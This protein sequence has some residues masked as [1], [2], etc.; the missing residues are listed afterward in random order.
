MIISQIE[1]TLSYAISD[2]IKQTN[3]QTNTNRNL[4]DPA[5]Y[6]CGKGQIL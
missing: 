5:S 6:K 1:Y 3:K 2:L 4:L